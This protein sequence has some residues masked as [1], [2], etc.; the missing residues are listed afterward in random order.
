MNV[1]QI[2]N[3][4]K[5]FGD[6]TAVNGL[7]LSI[8]K[9]EVFGLLGPNGVARVPRLI[10]YAACCMRHRGTSGYSEIRWRMRKESLALS[11][12]TLPCMTISLRMRT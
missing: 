12:K 10:W 8:E 4:V 7:N 11:R 3:L 1:I 2:D 9:G 6:Y 5:K